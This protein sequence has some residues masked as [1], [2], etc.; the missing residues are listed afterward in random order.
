MPGT[1]LRSPFSIGMIV[2]Y[3]GQNYELIDVRPYVRRRDGRDSL[4]LIWRSRCLD[5]GAVFDI[6][7]P[8]RKLK[9]SSRRCPDHRRSHK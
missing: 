4:V 6:G 3:R 9:P 7:A 8:Q 5:C 1:T 2:D